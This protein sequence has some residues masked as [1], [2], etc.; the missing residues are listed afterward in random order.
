MKEILPIT[1]FLREKGLLIDVRSPGEY[2][3]GHIPGAINLPLLN[4]EERAEVGTIYKREGQQKAFLAGLK[5]IGPKLASLVAS[6]QELHD[7]H[8]LP[9]VTNCGFERGQYNNV[10][11]YCWRGGMRSQSV[12]WLLKTAG[13]STLSLKGGYKAYRKWVLDALERPLPICVVGGYTGSG[14]TRILKALEQ[15]GEQMLDL[16][17][18]AH[19]RGSAYGLLG[20]SNS[21]PSQEHFENQTAMCWSRFNENVVWIE[22]ESRLIGTCRVPNGIFQQMLK[23]PLFLIERPQQERIDQLNEEYY[24]YPQEQLVKATERLRKKLGGARTQQ[25]ID[26]V[27]NRELGAIELLLNY[28]DRA[29]AHQLS[30]RTSPIYHLQGEALTD[31]EW[32]QEIL[33]HT[34]VLS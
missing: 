31:D 13:L 18:L 29:Y 6:A 30:K 2:R 11:V 28:Y 33:N 8:I 7:Q 19:H 1:S 24:C 10:R 4:D 17:A 26:Y 34:K 14:K 32:A 9:A 23:A 3:Q 21:Q 5:S 15:R 22:D 20:Q 16:E 25:A 12:A 27:R